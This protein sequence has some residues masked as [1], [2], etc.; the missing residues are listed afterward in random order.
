MK[1]LLP[2]ILLAFFSCQKT[3]SVTISD[4]ETKNALLLY[5][6]AD[7]NLSSYS[8]YD[9]V[10]I[11]TYFKS[12]PVSS[13]RVF[14]YRDTGSNPL[15][16]LY[17]IRLNYSGSVVYDS[18]KTYPDQDSSDPDVLKTVLQDFFD[19][20][21]AETYLLDLWSHGNG[22]Q[23]SSSLSTSKGLLYEDGTYMSIED[24][25]SALPNGVFECILFDACLMGNIETVYDLKAKANYI[26]ASPSEVPGYGMTYHTVLPKLFTYDYAGVS[27]AYFDYYD[28]YSKSEGISGVY[29]MAY[30]DDVRDAFKDLL[31][32][33]NIASISTT[34]VQS[35]SY[36]SY[37]LY[38][39][40]S[41]VESL[42]PITEQLSA[43][44]DALDKFIFY[45]KYKDDDSATGK[46]LYNSGYYG[47]LSVFSGVSIYIMG[48]TTLDASYKET[49]WYEDT[50]GT[51][52]Q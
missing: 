18:I 42:S 5:V 48:S 9:L 34:G 25:Q 52:S 15:P 35:V 14:V 23:T 29:E 43:F 30:I 40:L 19:Y 47:T 26:I 4:G 3:T 17:E 11:E 8:A 46:Y 39:M 28:T 20:V 44:E 22:W 21:T 36:Y 13:S 45:K 49:S 27:D 31:T 6:A 2:I 32:V 51:V 37:R 41:F 16:E 38:D 10:E 50:Y 1:Y 24:L 7:N 33:E 12:S